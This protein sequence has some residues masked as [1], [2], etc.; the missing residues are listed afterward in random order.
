MTDRRY[1]QSE[2]HLPAADQNIV[3]W[4]MLQKRIPQY[5]KLSKVRAMI[6]DEEEDNIYLREYAGRKKQRT[7][8]LK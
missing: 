3:S 8:N 6:K 7:D 2:K 5:E 1:S 4:D